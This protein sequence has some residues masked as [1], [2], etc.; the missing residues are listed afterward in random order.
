MPILLLDGM[1]T[2]E[3]RALSLFRIVAVM[4]SPEDQTERREY[5]V[6][7]AAK[8]MSDA[9]GSAYEELFHEQGSFGGVAEARPFSELREI[10]SKRID[11]WFVTSMM[12]NLLWRLSKSPRV[13]SDQT[14]VNKA[15][16]L[17][18]RQRNQ[19]N[20]DAIAAIPKNRNDIVRIWG[21]YRSVAHLCAAMFTSSYQPVMTTEKFREL[22]S[23]GLPFI[24]SVA[25]LYQRWGLSQPLPRT[26][27][28]V[29]TRPDLWEIPDEMN[30]PAVIIDLTPL[31]QGEVQLLREYRAPVP[32]S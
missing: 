19:G 16:F 20:A 10:W 24:L 18:E 11:H 22:I 4:G 7:R 2:P 6:A 3:E 5:L 26:K 21:R 9:P 29:L 12:I 1:N 31:T 17:I 15:A 27:R 23:E 28:M 14:S 25:K 32:Q 8:A 30:L 13:V